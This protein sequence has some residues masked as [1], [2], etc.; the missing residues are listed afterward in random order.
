ML[1]GTIVVQLVG[2]QAC[3]LK[4]V[5]NLLCKVDCWLKI[6]SGVFVRNVR[7][8]SLCFWLTFLFQ[9]RMITHFERSKMEW[10]NS[11]LLLEVETPLKVAWWSKHILLI[12]FLI[13]AWGDWCF[14][15]MRASCC[16]KSSQGH[17][18]P[19]GNLNIQ[20]CCKFGFLS[21]L[22]VYYSST[23]CNFSNI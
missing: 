11:F 13:S 20:S 1:V 2:T 10:R 23:F 22:N 18:K 4:E 19:F 17:D 7:R 9:E 14:I 15:V 8:I 3:I 12:C 6:H 16:G 21:N 5:I